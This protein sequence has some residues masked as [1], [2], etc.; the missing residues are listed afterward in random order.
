MKTGRMTSTDKDKLITG[1]GTIRSSRTIIHSEVI[2]TTQS[3]T[4]VIHLEIMIHSGIINP[5][6]YKT[7]SDKMTLSETMTYLEIET[8]NEIPTPSKM[9][10][11]L[12]PLNKTQIKSGKLVGLPPTT[13]SSA[14]EGHKQMYPP[15]PE[16][17][18]T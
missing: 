6:S 4:I 10:K 3:E 12:T 5:P 15:D 11:A 9:D 13:A 17:L 2:I 14:G 7:H 16:T 1:E 8:L 18:P